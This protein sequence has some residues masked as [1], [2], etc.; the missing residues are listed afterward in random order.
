MSP[1]KMIGLSFAA[2]AAKLYEV[3]DKLWRKSNAV[4]PVLHKICAVKRAQA[5]TLRGSLT[6]WPPLTL[7]GGFLRGG[8]KKQPGRYLPGCSIPW[9]GGPP[10]F[11]PLLHKRSTQQHWHLAGDPAVGIQTA[12]G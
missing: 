5:Q 7:S 9:G 4:T 1:K 12:A 3:F 2:A 11:S 10:R 6:V 8:M